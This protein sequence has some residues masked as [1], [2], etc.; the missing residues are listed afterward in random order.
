MTEEHKGYLISG[1]ALPG[2]PNT[3][4]WTMMATVLQCRRNGSVVELIRVR[5]DDWTLDFK[6]LAEWF[7]MELS[8]IIVDHAFSCR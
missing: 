8:R 3:F 1:S 2:P 5:L 6:E 7:G 4:Y